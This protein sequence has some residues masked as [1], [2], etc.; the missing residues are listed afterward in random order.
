MDPSAANRSLPQR[1][2]P[3]AYRVYSWITNSLLDHNPILI[4][5]QDGDFPDHGEVMHP[6]VVLYLE[7]FEDESDFV[8]VLEIQGVVIGDE[9]SLWGSF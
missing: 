6:E 7:E 2:A 1:R 3:L 5:M 4:L 9:V 8:P